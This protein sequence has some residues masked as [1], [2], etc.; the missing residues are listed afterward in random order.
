M[1]SK[2]S[3]TCNCNCTGLSVVASII[4][5]VITAILQFN[6]II[7]LTPAFL[8]VTLGIGVVY[9]GIVFVVSALNFDGPICIC[10]ILSVVLTGILGTI[11]LSMVL[12]GIS[13]AAGSIIGALLS[14]LL[15]AFFTLLITSAACLTKCSAGCGD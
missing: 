2:C 14:G 1:N 13:F 4:I 6:A 15:L 3:C 5:G 7:T 8:W 11:L 10:N 12:L 9:L